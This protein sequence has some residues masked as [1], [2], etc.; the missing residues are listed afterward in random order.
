MIKEQFYKNC[1]TSEG[2]EINREK[3]APLTI[4]GIYYKNTDIDIN[5]MSRWN[6]IV[7]LSK[8]GKVITWEALLNSDKKNE[9]G[10]ILPDETF[11]QVLDMQNWEIYTMWDIMQKTVWYYENRFKPEKKD[12]KFYRDIAI[13]VYDNLS[14]EEI[15]VTIDKIAKGE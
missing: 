4:D 3:F 1:L 14:G 6:E 7:Y 2:Q 12:I 13:K 5:D 9:M 8:Y 11:G 10:E 15:D